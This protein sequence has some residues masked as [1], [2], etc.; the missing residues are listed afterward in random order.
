MEGSPDYG[1]NAAIPVNNAN[2]KI[3]ITIKLL[4]VRN[5]T[6]QTRNIIS[7]QV[8]NNSR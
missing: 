7:V 5:G 6:G 4:R 2:N 3:T 1:Y 8:N